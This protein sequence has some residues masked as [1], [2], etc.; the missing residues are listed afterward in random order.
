M[1][2]QNKD[3]MFRWFDEVWNKSNEKAIDE[4]L[5]PEVNAFGL[6]PDTL[7]GV[8]NF[9][10]FYNAFRSAF[11]DINVAVDKN[12]VDGDYV[13]ALC[14]VKAKHNKTGKPVNFIGTSIAEVKN[15]QLLKGWNCFDFLGMNMQIGKITPEQLA[16]A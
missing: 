10:H 14:T 4:M 8:E 6:G 13:I 2:I 5:H 1:A 15:G 3:F 9:K 7:V 12:F 16:E 11:S